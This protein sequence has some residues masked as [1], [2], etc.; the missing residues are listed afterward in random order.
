MTFLY[1]WDFYLGLLIPFNPFLIQH[2]LS[3]AAVFGILT[4]EV[5][6]IFEG[7]L[8]S[9]GQKLDDGI[10]NELFSRIATIFLVGY[11]FF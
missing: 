7:L 10:L 3:I 11:I 1:T 4:Y 9:L 5:S 6:K 2:R 8:F